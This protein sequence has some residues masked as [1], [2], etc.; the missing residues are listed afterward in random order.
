MTRIEAGK[1]QKTLNF[2]RVCGY[3]RAIEDW[4]KGKQF[5]FSNRKVYKLKEE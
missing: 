4:N 2:S 1:R 5:E 3:I